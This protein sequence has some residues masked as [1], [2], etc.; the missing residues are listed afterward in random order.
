MTTWKIKKYS[1]TSGKPTHQLNVYYNGT[2]GDLNI[3]FNTDYYTNTSTGKG[4]LS[5][6]QSRARKSGCAYTELHQK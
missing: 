6:S 3:D 2:V 4:L 5:R 1:S